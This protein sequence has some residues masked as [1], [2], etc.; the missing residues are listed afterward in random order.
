MHGIPVREANGEI[1]VLSVEAEVEDEAEVEA[2]VEAEDEAEPKARNE[3]ARRRRCMGTRNCRERRRTNGVGVRAEG[4]ETGA[5][6][7]GGGGV[8]GG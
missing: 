2:E 7:E 5:D 4:A 1:M 6:G 3:T 8:G